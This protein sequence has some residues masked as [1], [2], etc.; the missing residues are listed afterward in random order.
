M[1]RSTRRAPFGLT[2]AVLAVS[3]ASFSLL[4]SMTVPT[5]PLL[6]EELGAD[7]AAASW[8]ITAQL[9]AAAVATPIIGRLGDALGKNRV[10]VVAVGSLAVGSLVA[11]LATSIEVLIA[12][13]VVQ[14]IGGGVIPLAFGIARDEFPPH[15]RASAISIIS[16]LLAVGFGV[17]IVIAGPI[18]DVVGLHWLFVIPAVVS[19]LA[20]VAA[21]VVIP[22]SPVRAAGGVSILPALL[23]AG[24]LT[25]LLLAVSQAPTWGWLSWEVLG[26]LALA[27][28]LTAAWVRS[29]QRAKAPVID[30]VMM[31][32]RPVWTTNLVAL[33]VGFSMYSSFGFVPQLLQ[34]PTSTG[35]GLGATVTQ[36]GLVMLP[37]ATMT[38]LMGLVATPLS[39]RFAPKA[40]V[41]AACAVAAA[42]MTLTAAWHDA[43]WHVAVGVG[44]T[45][46]G[47]GL[48]FSMLANLIVAAVPPEQ[49]GVATGMN[50]NLRTVGGAVGSAVATSIVTAHLLADGYA[51]ETG[52]TVT[53]VLLAVVMLAAALAGLLVPAAGTPER[54]PAAAPRAV[55]PAR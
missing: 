40:L 29:E 27:A 4:Q 24:W 53:F 42:G 23:L 32:R 16:S 2:F 51:S 10:L 26:L 18:V 11:A 6:Q 15:R 41:V 22:A 50:A 17:G 37:G 39:R 48:A 12:A 36:A 45:S 43:F 55:V 47:I 20:A 1:L 13:R 44:V 14:G 54:R 46:L 3:V 38:F 49:T 28:V 7:Q 19:A 31:R 35:Y 30:L 34:T 25:S 52:Y 8:I 9:L 21:A 5:L 33:L